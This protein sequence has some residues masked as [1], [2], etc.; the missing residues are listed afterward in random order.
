MMG[1]V[2]GGRRF[3]VFQIEVQYFMNLRMTLVGVLGMADVS[4][5]RD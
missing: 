5:Y 3:F 1:G 2:G 4:S